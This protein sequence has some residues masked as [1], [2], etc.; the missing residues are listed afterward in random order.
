MIAGDYAESKSSSKEV[1][2]IIRKRLLNT[3]RDNMLP[4]VYLLDSILKNVKGYYIDLVQDDA[5]KWMPMVHQKLQDAQRTKLSKVW[6]TWE[7]FQI[8]NSDAWK[9]MGRCFDNQSLVSSAKSVVGAALSSATGI[10]R[11]V[12]AL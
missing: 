6:K 3:N 5:A 4:L 10:T 1:Y 7:E 9:E 12:R 2:Q 8:F 11:A